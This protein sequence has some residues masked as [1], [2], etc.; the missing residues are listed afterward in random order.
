MNVD[1]LR[2][3][4]SVATVGWLPC[5]A[6]ALPTSEAV[7]VHDRLMALAHRAAGPLS[8]AGRVRQE[9]LA[10]I[11][12]SADALIVSVLE[13]LR[14]LR[15]AGCAYSFEAVDSAGVVTVERFGIDEVPPV[16]SA[17]SVLR[18]AQ[19]LRLLAPFGQIEAMRFL[20]L[21]AALSAAE[22]DLHSSRL[23]GASDERVSKLQSVAASIQEKIIKLR[24]QLPNAVLNWLDS[25]ENYISSLTWTT[26][27]LPIMIGSASTD[28]D[29][30]EVSE[31]FDRLS[32]QFYRPL[33]IDTG[34]PPE[35]LTA[36]ERVWSVYE[37]CGAAYAV[38]AVWL[39]CIAAVD[40]SRRCEICYRH[41]GAGMRR[42]CATH[43]RTAKKRQKA[44]E[45]HVAALYRKSVRSFLQSA[46]RCLVDVADRVAR[47]T[48]IQRMLCVAED[49]NVPSAL[50][51]P[52]ATLAAALR[53]LWPVLQPSLQDLAQQHFLR[54]LS[55]ARRP[56]D[57]PPSDNAL[58][59]GTNSMQRAVT[60]RWLCLDVFV[61]TWF[62][63]NVVVPWARPLTLGE[64]YDVDNPIR[65]SR[66]V[67]PSKL[68]L[69]L[70]FMRSWFWVG[71]LFDDRA[72]LNYR[73]VLDL[74]NRG[75][76]A[77][78]RPSLA[79]IGAILGASA[80]AVRETLHHASGAGT[81]SPRRDRVLPAALLK[82]ERMI[83][84]G[85]DDE[86][87]EAEPSNRRGRRE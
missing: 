31:L 34:I 82:L 73:S 27:S 19:S 29:L 75:G 39:R 14:E 52:A 43:T 80:E 63:S 3:R 61:Q 53:E 40:E 47:P 59:R 86:T 83:A 28:A 17:A 25:D 67:L 46:P 5:A 23:A 54:L 42:Y 81:D 69:D 1:D 26:W 56:F 24:W 87:I 10:E 76:G 68:A 9:L 20:N 36:I 79:Q 41:L 58:E 21:Q 32:R 30:L 11:D 12:R 15:E 78:N 16:S 64:G 65:S 35:R 49:N 37:D 85:T 8:A 6:N 44:R 70:T 51:L 74:R 50:V 66:S 7:G 38:L 55:I 77:V 2:A 60:P 22:A 13:C 62:C 33:P 18:A 4:V 57:Q 71:Q 45:L 72:Y 84:N 48:D